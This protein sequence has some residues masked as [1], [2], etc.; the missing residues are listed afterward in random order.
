MHSWLPCISDHASLHHPTPPN[1]YSFSIVT[2]LNHFALVYRKQAI[3]QLRACNYA[4]RHV[5]GKLWLSNCWKTQQTRSGI[6]VYSPSFLIFALFHCVVFHFV[7]CVWVL[8]VCLIKF[9]NFFFFFAW[10]QWL[11]LTNKYHYTEVSC[12]KTSAHEKLLRYSCATVRARALTDSLMSLISL[13]MSSMNV[14]MKS[15]NLCLYMLSVWVFV[16]KK[17]IS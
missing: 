15:I 16:T 6:E 11:H 3:L 5:P 17:L 10:I 1:I 13:S 7:L 4:S 9:V 8:G 14:M 2:L 12:W